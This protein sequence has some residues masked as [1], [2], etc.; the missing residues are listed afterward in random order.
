MKQALAVTWT[1]RWPGLYHACH[2]VYSVTRSMFLRWSGS[3][4]KLWGSES[5]LQGFWVQFSVLQVHLLW[6]KLQVVLPW[7]S[8]ELSAMELVP[9]R[10]RVTSWRSPPSAIEQVGTRPT[11]WACGLR[12]EGFESPGTLQLLNT[13]WELLLLLLLYNY[14]LVK[15]MFNSP[16]G[17]VLSFKS[18][19]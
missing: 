10:M 19:Y 18:L 17:W 15:T 13:Q 6:K 5:F 9:L 2:V 4:T 3:S 14:G 8:L 11:Q 1:G 12:G 7:G 16:I